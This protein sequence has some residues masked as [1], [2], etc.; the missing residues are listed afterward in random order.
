MS[1]ASNLPAETTT[2]SDELVVYQP[3]STFEVLDR[4]AAETVSFEHCGE[5]F[6]GIF[7]GLEEVTT[8]DGEQ[9]PLG[10]FTGPDA[11][12]YA[13]FPNTVMLRGLRKLEPG[14]W[15]RITY[16]A[17]VDT[18]KPSPLKSFVVEGAR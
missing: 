15:A 14:Q 18:G 5:S 16:V 8:D 17:D 7:E 1:P 10:R 6:V 13:I 12:A 3:P 2:P 11:K 4:G 9:L